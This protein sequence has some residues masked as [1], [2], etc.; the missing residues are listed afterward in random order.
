MLTSVLALRQL[1]GTNLPSEGW[2]RPGR[3]G[4]LSSSSE[5]GTDSEISEQ[6]D[7]SVS[8]ITSIM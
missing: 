8:S 7:I 5:E 3:D 6:N 1:S 4:M 2:D